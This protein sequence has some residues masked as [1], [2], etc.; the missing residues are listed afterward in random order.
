MHAA[1]IPLAWRGLHARAREAAA[2]ALDAAHLSGSDSSLVYAHTVQCFTHTQAG[3]ANLASAPE[4][5][6]SRAAG[7]SARASSWRSRTSTSARRCWR[8]ASPSARSSSSPR[9]RARGAGEH[10]VGRCW[11][12]LWTARAHLRLG[13][14]GAGARVARAGVGDRRGDGADRPA[15][16]RDARSRR[17]SANSGVRWRSRPPSCCSAAAAAS[18]TPRA[19]P[20]GR[21]ARIQELQRARA[22]F[23]ECGAPAP[24]RPGGERAAAARAAGGALRGAGAGTLSAREQEIAELVGSGRTN[25]QIAA[26][27]ASLREHRREPPVARVR[28]SSESHRGPRWR[29]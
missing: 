28:G 3:E 5:R 9:A 26:R 13:D 11:W 12:E 24:R 22:A 29:P 2:A 19:L 15:R 4:R 25:R 21:A 8:P 1:P 6:P 7:G 23:V 27:A 18:R 16:R 17:S 10:Y 14:A 20:H